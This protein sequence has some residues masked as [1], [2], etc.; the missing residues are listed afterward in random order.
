[1]TTEL[2]LV[3]T[4]DLIAELRR[5]CDSGILAVSFRYTDKQTQVG[6]QVWGDPIIGC[7]LCEIAKDAILNPSQEEDD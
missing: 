2:E 7:G 4:E 5:R 6:I 1:M 3:L